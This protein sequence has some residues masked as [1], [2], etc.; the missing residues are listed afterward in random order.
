MVSEGSLE[1]SGPTYSGSDTTP[2]I[3]SRATVPPLYPITTKRSARWFTRGACDHGPWVVVGS[4]GNT[5]NVADSATALFAVPVAGTSER[6]KGTYAA[7][8]PAARAAPTAVSSAVRAAC[9]L[10]ASPSAS[11]TPCQ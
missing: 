6:L 3:A 7:T 5:T 4:G 2:P 10:A 9:D 11:Q 1:G 8:R